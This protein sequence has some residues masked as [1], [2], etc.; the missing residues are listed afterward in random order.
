[1]V[2]SH[3]ERNVNIDSLSAPLELE[4]SKIEKRHHIPYDSLALLLQMQVM[5]LQRHPFHFVYV[6]SLVISFMHLV[7][8]NPANT[9]YYLNLL[10]LAK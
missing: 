9:I 8:S 4:S 6:L 3:P 2:A 7:G 5:S 1:M 10:F